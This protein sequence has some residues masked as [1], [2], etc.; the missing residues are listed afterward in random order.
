MLLLL[1]LRLTTPPALRLSGDATPPQR[2]PSDSPLLLGAALAHAKLGRVDDARA[3][4][5]RAARADPAHAHALQ[6]WGVFEE[7]CGELRAAR[8]CFEAGLR[9]SPRHAALFHA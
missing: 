2:F 3:L 4:F 9:E 8:R 6:A 1:F 5:G 7:R